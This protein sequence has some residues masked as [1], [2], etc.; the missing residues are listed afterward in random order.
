MNTEKTKIPLIVHFAVLMLSLIAF[1]VGFWHTHLGLKEMRPFESDYGSI[2]IA[3]II[4][5]L[6]LIS[7]FFAIAGKGVALLIYL[8]CACFFIVFNLNFFYPSYLGRQLVK[9]EAIRLNDT[10]QRFSNRVKL[11]DKSN[12]ADVSELH[13]LQEK[14]YDEIKRQSGFGPRATDYL[15]QFNA[16]TGGNLKAN[17][18]IG[19]TQEER[20]EIAAAY[21]KLLE[22]EIENY[23]VKQMATGNTENANKL[24]QGVVA[25]DTINKFYSPI[26]KEIIADDNRV[27][28]E[29]VKTHPQINH[30]QRLITSL[31]DATIK[32]NEASNKQIF[33]KLNEAKT[34]NLGRIAH[35]LNSI[36]ERI[37]HIDTW[38]MILLCLFI[39]L[40]VPL[41]IYILIRKKADDPGITIAVLRKHG[42]KL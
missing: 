15:N 41:A 28:L 24:Y 20:E 5:L 38:A 17:I 42:R 9:E 34:R 16:I 35:T 13:S 32:I 14:I 12:I 8:I 39:D 36:M 21:N 7:Y 25:L 2:L 3:S 11:I 23:V 31:D 22:K 18:R 26:L 6:L 30:L 10:L 1:A 40:L 19:V 27:Q 29:S 4:L 33:P 37:N